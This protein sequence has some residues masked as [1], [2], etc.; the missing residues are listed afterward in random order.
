LDIVKGKHLSPFYYL[1]EVKKG[2]VLKNVDYPLLKMEEVTTINPKRKIKISLDDLVPY[3]G[4][5]ETDEFSGEV[6]NIISRP[7][8]DVKGRGVTKKGDILFARIEPSIYNRKY[9]Y[10]T[11]LKEN[12]FTLTSTEFYVVEPKG[13]ITGKYLFYML[14]SN[15]VYN[16]ILGK[17]TGTTGRRR[18]DIFAFRD[19]LIPV[20]PLPIQERIAYEVQNRREKAKK[21]KE[22][23]KEHLEKAKREVEELIEKNSQK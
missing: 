10:V 9:I 8:R 16:Q 13:D 12:E 19:I 7:Y 6:K 17:I 2:S 14:R 5:P 18:L 1:F 20:P 23:A 4:L 3:I 15:F 22:E 21:L 11:D